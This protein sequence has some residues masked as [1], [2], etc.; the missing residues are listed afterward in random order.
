M[1]YFAAALV[2]LS[3]AVCLGQSDKPYL[4]R[5]PAISKTQVAFNYDGDL[6]IADRNGGDTHRLTAGIGRQTDPNACS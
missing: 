4:L 5:K 1:R 3:A 2:V 6:W